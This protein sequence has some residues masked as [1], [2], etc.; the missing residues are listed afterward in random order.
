MQRDRCKNATVVTRLPVVQQVQPM[1]RPATKAILTSMIVVIIAIIV[2]QAV[3]GGRSASNE[4]RE[5]SK[6]HITIDSNDETSGHDSHNTDNNGESSKNVATPINGR[7]NSN[8]ASTVSP[9]DDSSSYQS[10]F[11]IED[12]DASN[13]SGA[14]SRRATLQTAREASERH[15]AIGHDITSGHD[16]SPRIEETLSTPINEMDVIY[17]WGTSAL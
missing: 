14:S 12:D 10:E 13:N 9:M 4:T 1:T 16:S 8:D 3:G 15:I 5:A 17:P 6:R 2:V 11:S 7:G